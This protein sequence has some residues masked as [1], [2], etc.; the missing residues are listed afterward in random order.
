LRNSDADAG[1]LD[2]ARIM[3]LFAAK[4]GGMVTRYD[5]GEGAEDVDDRDATTSSAEAAR[6]DSR[7]SSGDGKGGSGALELF[8]GEYQKQ[9]FYAEQK[10]YSQN[11]SLNPGSQTDFYMQLNEDEKHCLVIPYFTMI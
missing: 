1:R 9:K 8:Q 7:Q 2:G 10:H 11:P 3:G 6:A 5:N 4:V